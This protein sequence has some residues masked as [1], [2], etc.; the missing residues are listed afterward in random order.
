[1]LQFGSQDWAPFMDIMDHNM[2][3]WESH[4]TFSP[5]KTSSLASLNHHCTLRVN[6]VSSPYLSAQNVPFFLSPTELLLLSS[7]NITYLVKSRDPKPFS[8]F[9][10]PEDSAHHIHLETIKGQMHMILFCVYILSLTSL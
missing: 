5:L 1:M 10:T 3:L 6:A 8:L 7:P 9:Q 4:T 2:H